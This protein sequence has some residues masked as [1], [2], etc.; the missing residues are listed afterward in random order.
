MITVFQNKN[1]FKLFSG[2]MATNAGDSIYYVAAMWL[3]YE[4]GGSAFYT[5]LAGFLTLIPQVLQF[6]TG[7]VID[8]ISIRKLLTFSQGLQAFM[9]LSIPIAHSLGVLNVT[10]VLIVMP[11][12]SLLNQ[13]AYPATS[14]LIPVILPKEQLTK[15]NSLMS[16]AY[17]GVDMVFN[18]VTGLLITFFGA[19]TLFWTDS[20]IFFLAALLYW[21]M[22]IGKE[23]NV[24]KEP[25]QEFSLKRETRQYMKDLKA[26]FQLVL[27][28]AIVKLFGE[29]IVANFALGAMMAILPAYADFRGGSEVYGALLA[30]FSAG[31]LVGSLCAPLFEKIPV[32]KITMIS[33]LLG[34]GFW[35]SSVFMPIN[36]ISVLLFG[37]CSIPIGLT[38]VLFYTILQGCVPRK[39]LA[40]VFSVIASISTSAMPLGSLAGGA[41]G[42][43]FPSNMV[44][45]GAGFSFLFISLYIALVPVLRNLPSVKNATMEDFKF[46]QE[47]LNGE[48]V[49]S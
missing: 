34:A 4:L 45:L 40:R 32:G 42:S 46:N 25:A 27:G 17:Q 10:I 3:V 49:S 39:F 8:R 5:G 7:P 48:T 29:N 20:V 33:F 22:T 23:K 37:I 41:L 2:R 28:S 31:V 47:I 36:W 19:I 16:F 15:G 13:I 26:G 30:A 38:N 12:I 43:L 11:V 1:F 9:I 24:A 6:L 21:R 14:A 35:I 18:A 44:F